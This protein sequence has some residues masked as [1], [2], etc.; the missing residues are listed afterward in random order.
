VVGDPL[1][2]KQILINL[3]GNAIKFTQNGEIILKVETQKNENNL[4]QF[5]ISIIDTGIGI[6]KENLDIIFDEYVQAENTEGIKYQGTGLGLS[7]VKKLVELHN[8]N[9]GF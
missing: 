8:G 9:F 3:I 5:N 6:S 7:I 4:F 2:L 1:R